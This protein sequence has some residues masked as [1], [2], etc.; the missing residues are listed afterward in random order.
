[1]YL[2]K[3]FIKK[4][5]YLKKNLF[6]KKFI[7]KKYFTKMYKSFYSKT[8]F[9]NKNCI[10]KNVLLMNF[11][12][13]NVFIEKYFDWKNN[14]NLK[15]NVLNLFETNFIINIQ[16]TFSRVLKKCNIFNFLLKLNKINK[17]ILCCATI[18]ANAPDAQNQQQM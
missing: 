3:T 16:G 6:K 18:S 2:K 11:I 8:C 12:Q 10:Q 1:M 4:K 14:F 7:K 9:I 5:N 13:E 17:K 15:P